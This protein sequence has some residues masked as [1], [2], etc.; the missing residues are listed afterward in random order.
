VNGGALVTYST[1]VS[2]YI[3]IFN[4]LL[5]SAENNGSHLD[6]MLVVFHLFCF[7]IVRAEL[8]GTK[9]S[10]IQSSVLLISL[11]LLHFLFFSQNTLNDLQF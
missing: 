9:Y 8:V 11:P 6:H 2:I 3:Y 10:D 5:Y 1:L 4:P 7:E